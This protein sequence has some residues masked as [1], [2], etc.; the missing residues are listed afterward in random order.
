MLIEFFK[1]NIL[2]SIIFSLTSTFFKPAYL[3]T[4]EENKK[5]VEIYRYF[6]F[7]YLKFN[8]M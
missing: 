7:N 3:I 1:F 6:I 8:N 2:I 5:R 4:N